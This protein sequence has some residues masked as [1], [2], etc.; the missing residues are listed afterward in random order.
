MLRNVRRYPP[1]I[2]IALIVA[3]VALGLSVAWPASSSQAVSTE[4]FLTP[5]GRTALEPIVGFLGGPT[6]LADVRIDKLV[7]PTGLGS[8]EF[9]VNFNSEVVSVL[10]VTEG[11]YLSSTGRVTTCT[12]PA[13]T[14]T[15]V[16][17]SCNS[18]ASAPD[19]PLGS[20]V[21]ATIEFLPASTFGSK[22]STTLAFAKTHLTDI[23]GDVLI[24]HA[25]LGGSVLVAKCGD[26]NGDKVVTVGDIILISSRFGANQGPPP[27]PDWDPA[28]DLNGDGAVTIG[29]LL[30]EVQQFGRQCNA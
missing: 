12:A 16:N 27:T 17:F 5:A 26:F 2:G 1:S 19:G 11:P 22:T 13:I 15:S 18:F 6:E 4:V 23:S 28:F 24:G 7:F 30:I 3:A 20:G 25:A 14:T 9:T 10:D 29:D 21:L 8:F